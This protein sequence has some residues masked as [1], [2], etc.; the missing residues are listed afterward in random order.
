MNAVKRRT[1]SN[2]ARMISAS[3]AVVIAIG[4]L[5]LWLPISSKARVFTPLLDCLFTAASAT[6]VTGLVVYDTYTHW[7][8]FGHGV[9]LMLIQIGGLGL[10]TFTSFFNLV[11]GRKLGLRGMRLASES[12]NSTSFGDVPYLLRM[13]ITFT[14]AVEA[15]GA[16]LLGL[17]FVPRFGL[18][19]IAIS[20]FLAI[21]AFCNAGFDVLGFLGEYT[22][23]TSLNDSY[24]VLF[25]IML[26][27]IIGGLG[28]IVWNDL[29]AWRKTRTLLLHT[30]VVLLV[31][32]FLLLLG[33]VCFLLFEWNN[34]ATL[35]PMSLKEKIGAGC[36]QSVTMRTAGFNSI[37]LYSM[38]DATK[39]FSIVLMFIGAAPGSTGGGIKVTTIAVIVMTAVSISR[40]KDEPYL[41]GRRLSAN[42]VYRS[43]AILFLGIVVSGITAIILILTCPLEQNGLTGVDAAFE[44]VSAFA[45]V[46]V[47]SGVT[48][49][50]NWVGKIALTLTMF[51]GRV[52]PVSFGLTLA[53][54][55]KINR[56]LI[57]PEGK[58]VVG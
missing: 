48:A 12:I 51:I 5:L 6:C 41:L 2:P 11:V 36:L 35:Q 20:V 15:S 37:D 18:R 33:T 50:T 45:T 53:A 28:F 55:Q 58:I 57:V 26:L 22:S 34:P 25:T 49:V 32:A 3:F 16:L 42:V 14:L 24:L 10:V 9:L 29:M 31:T 30:K 44:A 1:S 46:G 8:A 43:L 52:G 21:S 17:Y 13:I 27:I 23:L 4:T 39:V 56:K 54:Q 38:H 40:G 7:S 19:G 47:S